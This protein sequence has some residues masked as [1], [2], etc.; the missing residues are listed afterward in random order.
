MKTKLHNPSGLR[1]S[2]SSLVRI[3]LN[4]LS[5]SIAIL[6]MLAG[7]AFAQG[8]IFGGPGK[9]YDPKTP[10]PLALNEAYR[11]ALT[12]IGEVTNRFY[13]V[14]A[15]CLEKTLPEQAGWVFFFSNTNGDRARV[16][17]YFHNK[18]AHI[19]DA[20]SVELLK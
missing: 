17:V 11:L 4:R 1:K 3:V 9:P 7:L 5:I 10:P 18:G 2:R 19:P 12:R 20:A 8:R 13:C 15:S 6:A 16:E 14:S